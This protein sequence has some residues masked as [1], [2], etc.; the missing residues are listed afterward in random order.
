MSQSNNNQMLPGGRW[1]RAYR[2]RLS[3]PL[4][5]NLMSMFVALFGSYQTKIAFDLIP[6][7]HY[8]YGVLRSAELASSCGLDA[9]SI[10]ELGV[11][12]GAGLLNLCE[13]AREVTKATG[14][15][16][17]IYGFDTGSGL[18]LPQDHRDHPELFQV[19]D[20]PMDQQAL[21]RAL[22]SN[23]KLILGELRDT[24]PLFINELGI[25]APLGFVAVDIDYYSS[26]KDALTLFADA[27]PRKYL[28]FSIVYLDDIYFESQNRWCGELLAVQ[29]FN[30]A[31]TVRKIEPDRFLRTRRIF[32]HPRWIDQIYLLHTLDHPQRQPSGVKRA[33]KTYPHIHNGDSARL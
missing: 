25:E 26:A 24:V 21:I 11:A 22:P 14:V 19:G 27:E 9:V 28:P 5:L 12:A 17:N 23:A 3:E 13:I 1:A 32:K 10:V 6:R 8:A 30:H 2:E 29:E 33:T 31:Q 16:F 15:R 4:H 7:R 20:F 18:P